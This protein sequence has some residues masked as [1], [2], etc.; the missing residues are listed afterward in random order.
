MKTNQLGPVVSPLSFRHFM[1]TELARRCARNKQYSLRA[2]ANFLQV[3]HS[4]L[5]QLLR[6]SRKVTART[7]RRLGIRLGLDE[8]SLA[9]FIRAAER[10]FDRDE[11]ALGEIRKLASETAILIA[12]W[13]HYAIL[14][15]VRLH[16][17][18]PDSRWIAR[19]LD[20]GVDEVNIAL[21]RLARLGLL[22]MDAPDR[23]TDRS[24]DVTA[25]VHGFTRAALQQLIEHSRERLVGAMTRHSDKRCVFNSTTL[26]LS[27]A[28]VA[29]AA[30]RIE[31][32]R[33]ELLALVQTGDRL[34]EVYQLEI[35]LV[36]LTTF[37][38]LEVSDGT[39]RDSLANRD[40][41]A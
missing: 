19:V 36:P 41:P 31:Q 30:Q 23:W 7:I 32:L 20:L 27:S 33:R 15:L 11:N 8:E 18:R 38:S 28:R 9:E 21:Q 2:F 3:D 35:S 22:S 13:Q 16:T 24:G 29:E 37:E 4:T 14:E 5:S 1:Q 26:A 17:F 40:A 25:S 10:S 6:G 34:D 12:E 39:T